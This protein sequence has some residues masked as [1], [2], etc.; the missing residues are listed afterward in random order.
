V[1]TGR[2]SAP[3]SIGRAGQRPRFARPSILWALG[4]IVAAGAALRFATLGVQSYHHD[5][6]IT[7][8]RV[9]PGSFRHMFDQI[10][11]SESNPPLY[12]VVAWTWSKL[13][14]TGEAGLRSLSALLG[15]A[16]I[17]VAFLAGRE[18]LSDRAGLIAAAIVAVNPMLIWYSQ[19]ARSYAMLIFFGALSLLFFL[20]S[21][22]G[23][24]GR[25]LACWGLA[26]A[27]AFCSHY[28]AGFA[29]AIEA[30][31]LLVALP[32]RRRAVLIAVG[33]TALV[34]VALLPLLLSQLS[35]IKTGWIAHIPLSRRTFHAAVSFL[36]GETGGVIAERPR[37]GYALVPA[38]LV[39]V[40]LL[41]LAV[42]GSRRERR[43]ALA[44]LVVGLG[45]VLAP[46]LLALAGKDYL[47]GRNLLPALAPL[48][49]VAA[50]GLAAKRAGRIGPACATALCAYW[51]AF[52][53]YIP[54]TPSLQR[55]DFRDAAARLGA[56][57]GP[58]AIVTWKLGATT[59]RYYLHHR[60]ERL[61][62]GVRVREIDVIGKP[63]A[64][65]LSASVPP[66]FHEVERI[67]VGR[68]VITRYRSQR[69][70][71]VPYYVL[72]RLH[73]GFGTNGAVADG[74]PR[75]RPSAQA[76]GP[77]LPAASRGR[78]PA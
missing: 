46:L 71:L 27:A 23:A 24:R 25:D 17:P 28:F 5:E 64:K 20:R 10:R 42:R 75:P 22:H 34:G 61:S 40:A 3:A 29:V 67:G 15:A 30:V 52:A 41:L 38:L 48:A 26:S 12:Y 8:A 44:P 63:K 51:L 45:V 39:G 73:T 68:L 55:P 18:A 54:F 57:H 77:R 16:T 9:L 36:I 50:I 56:P 21:L 35:A 53:I 33:G 62:G 6:I 7:V 58:R 70:Q 66:A 47:D 59:M 76:P 13:F 37:T 31:W 14:G 74:L 78:G 43:A 11:K 2:V 19:E 32:A 60:S 49:V 72:S 4:G 65:G 69:L 1:A